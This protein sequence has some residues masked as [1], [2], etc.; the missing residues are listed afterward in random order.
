MKKVMDHGGTAIFALL[1]DP[2]LL[3]ARMRDIMYE[4][5]F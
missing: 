4:Q 2:L 5:Q 1:R 3:T